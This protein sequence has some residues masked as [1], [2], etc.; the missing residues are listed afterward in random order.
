[1]TLAP[2]SVPSNDASA[3]A[4]FAIVRPPVEVVT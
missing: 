1:L 3:P 2:L 4:L